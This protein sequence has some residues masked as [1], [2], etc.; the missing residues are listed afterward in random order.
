MF[1]LLT[2]NSTE[3]W[4]PFVKLADQL[5]IAWHCICDGD[6]SGRNNAAAAEVQLKG[7]TRDEHITQYSVNTV[8]AY[9]CTLGFDDI[10]MNMFPR[11]GGNDRCTEGNR[12]SR[13]SDWGGRHSQAQGKSNLEVCAAIEAD[14]TRAPEPLRS[15][16]QTCCRVAAQ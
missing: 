9:L 2:V 7:R 11:E 5:G 10:Y 12:R 13:K 4:G 3:E 8:E 6:E 15:I 14:S 1:V 16:F